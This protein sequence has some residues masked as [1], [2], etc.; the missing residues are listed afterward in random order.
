MVF[1]GPQVYRQVHELSWRMLGSDKNSSV[2]REGLNLY[3]IFRGP[4]SEVT[5]GSG[6]PP[7]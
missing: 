1:C 2:I 5:N 4:I 7:S 3:A 6:D